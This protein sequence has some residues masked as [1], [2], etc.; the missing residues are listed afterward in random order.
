MTLP[1]SNPVVLIHGDVLIDR[2]ALSEALPNAW[3]AVLAEQEGG[4]LEVWQSATAQVASDW[5][6]YWEDLDLSG[7]DSLAQW[8]EGRW[9]IVRAWFRLAGQAVPP[10]SRL[11]ALLDELPRKVGRR[12]DAWRNGALEALHGLAAAGIA[13]RIIEPF[14]PGSLVRGMLDTAKL[15]VP[16]AGPDDLGQVGLEGLDCARLAARIGCDP[17]RCRFVSARPL[18]GLPTLSPPDDLSRLAEWLC[19]EIP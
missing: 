19:E 9:R 8:R 4:P 5:D 11:S 3:A 7:D 2:R 17:A 1:E 14:A 16:V 13:A 15:T 12:L 18:P 10:T 6:S